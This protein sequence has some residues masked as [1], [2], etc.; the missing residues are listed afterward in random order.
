MECEFDE[1]KD[2][3][4]RQKHGLPLNFGLKIFED[5]DHIFIASIREQDKEERFKVVGM[6]EN[7]LFTAV[8][9]WRGD[10]PQHPR[11]ISVRRSNNAEQKEYNRNEG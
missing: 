2:Q 9:V 4:N 8:F 7:R 1:R 11:F 10:Y 3:T 5:E 6:V